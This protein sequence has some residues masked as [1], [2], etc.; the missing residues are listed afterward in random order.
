MLQKYIYKKKELL[1]SEKIKAMEDVLSICLA[2]IRAYDYF[3]T[4][5]AQTPCHDYQLY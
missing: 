1:E 4:T 2:V 5:T 3:L